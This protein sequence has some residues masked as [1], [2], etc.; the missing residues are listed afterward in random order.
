VSGLRRADESKKR[1]P[2][3]GGRRSGRASPH[4][5]RGDGADGIAEKRFGP[6]GPAEEHQAQ[7][8]E[9]RVEGVVDYLE[10][11]PALGSHVAQLAE[12]QVDRLEQQPQQRCHARVRVDKR[13][14]AP[15]ESA[16]TVRER[17]HPSVHCH[18]TPL[19]N[20]TQRV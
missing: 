1:D 11:E 14:A 16:P 20:F 13:A 8:G 4:L 19:C 5:Q 15:H 10:R 7:A 3:E 6:A 12:P 17:R 18:R 9:R 2:V